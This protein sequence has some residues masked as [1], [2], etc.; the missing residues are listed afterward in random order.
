MRICRRFLIIDVGFKGGIRSNGVRFKVKVIGSFY[1]IVFKVVGFL[2][3]KNNKELN[4][5][6]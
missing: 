1:V 6:F 2:I 4:L 5:F 3:E